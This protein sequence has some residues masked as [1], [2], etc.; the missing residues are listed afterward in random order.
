MGIHITELK[1][2]KTLLRLIAQY[3]EDQKRWADERECHWAFFQL[4]FDEFTPDEIKRNFKWEVPVGVPHY[5]TGNKSAAV[6]LV[7]MLDDGGWIGIEIE[8]PTLSPGK[9][10]ERE[11]VKCV[12]KLKTAPRSKKMVK[13]YL[14]PL[15]CASSNRRARGY[16]MTNRELIEK[17]ISEA[18]KLIPPANIELIMD[19][20]IWK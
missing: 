16:G 3:Q 14:V 19:G 18:E 10:L 6:D 7:W 5:G 15:I 8:G 4:L 12:V 2:R 20:V 1:I 17:N 9:S 11:L 13:G